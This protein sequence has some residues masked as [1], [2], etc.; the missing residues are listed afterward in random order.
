[1]PGGGG[2]PREVGREVGGSGGGGQQRP[3]GEERLHMYLVSG[4][5][6]PRG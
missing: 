5:A 3:E 2:I 6:W 4:S 1:M